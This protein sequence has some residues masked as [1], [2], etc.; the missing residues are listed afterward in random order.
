MRPRRRANGQARRHFFI[1]ILN[2]R[3]RTEIATAVMEATQRRRPHAG[4]CVPLCAIRRGTPPFSPRF[5]LGFSLVR[6]LLMSRRPSH[7]EQR[8]HPLSRRVGIEGFSGFRDHLGRRRRL[9]P[10]R[11]VGGGAALRYTSDRAA[12]GSGDRVRQAARRESPCRAFTTRYRS[13]ARVRVIAS[14]SACAAAPGSVARITA[15]ITATPAAPVFAAAV[16]LLSSIPPT[17][18]SGR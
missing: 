1:S 16:A 14:S 2:L 12:P 11:A 15:R 6:G 10:G 13:H 18:T 5:S 17:A 9:R 4:V 3:S 8:C 7:A